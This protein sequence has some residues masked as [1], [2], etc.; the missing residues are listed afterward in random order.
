MPKEKWLIEASALDEFQTSVLQTRIDD[1]L[2]VS[3]CA[4]SGKTLLAFHRAK[5]IQDSDPDTDKELFFFLVKTR[6][7]KDFITEGSSQLGIQLA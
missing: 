2:V 7:L 4:G 6:A 1:H 3:G 5:Q